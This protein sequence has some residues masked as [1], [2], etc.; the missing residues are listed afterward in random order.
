MSGQDINPFGD[1][2][3]VNPFVPT[4]VQV[5]PP[6][7]QYNPAVN[8]P[9]QPQPLQYPA[10]TPPISQPAPAYQPAPFSNQPPQQQQ[11]GIIPAVT[12]YGQ[13]QYAP[14][15]SQ[16]T[17][18]PAYT[19]VSLNS[20]Q[21]NQSELD[22]RANELEARE[23]ELNRRQKNAIKENN[24]P[25]LPSFIS[26]KPCYYHDITGEIPVANQK[27]C[28]I[29]YYIWQFYVL[30]LGVNFISGLGLLISSGGEEAGA[31]FGVSML[32][33]F[34]FTPCSFVCWYRPIY[35]ALRDD[36][37]FNYMLFFFVFFCQII[38]CGVFALGI[39]GFRS[40]GWINGISQAS[41]GNG[42]VAFL[43]FATAMMWTLLVL[44]MVFYLKRI[45]SAYRSS[46]A[47]IEK[48][49]GE[50]AVGI[51]TNKAVQNVAI[52]SMRAGVSG[53]L[54]PQQ[55]TRQ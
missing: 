10:S 2:K 42:F 6:P 54:Q 23:Q 8:R 41:S 55:G 13:P 5:A 29:M 52:E 9:L 43:M 20:H 48:A 35:K 19:P 12:G 14:Q 25:P 38:L 21:L 27:T 33:M 15:Q 32:Y 26:M 44:S 37:S 7:Q 39:P 53:G 16:Y 51:A 17:V 36:S 24:F 4:P 18:P 49:Q 31:T 47:S 46:G 28:K 11:P 40:I 34:L 22:R 45:H 30:T 3:E 50:L 1:P